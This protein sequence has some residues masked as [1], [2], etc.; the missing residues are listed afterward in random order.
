MNALK[1]SLMAA[2]EHY[3]LRK[4]K[5]RLKQEMCW[6]IDGLTAEQLRDRFERGERE[7]GELTVEIL[8]SMN[9]HAMLIEEVADAFWYHVMRELSIKK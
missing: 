5:D 2:L 8:A 9:P 7:H 6:A 3:Q 4:H 1:N